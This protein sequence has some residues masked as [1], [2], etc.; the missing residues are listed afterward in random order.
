M[1]ITQFKYWTNRVL[2]LFWFSFRTTNITPETTMKSTSNS[3]ERRQGNRI[4]CKRTCSSEEVEMET[5]SEEKW[6]S[7]SGLTRHRISTIT[8]FGG[9]HQISCPY[10][11][12]RIHAF[13]FPPNHSIYRFLPFPQIFSRQ[14]TDSKVYKKERRHF[15]NKTNVG[16]RFNM[17]CFLVGDREWEIQG[18]LSLPAVRSQVPGLQNKR[19]HGGGGVLQARHRGIEPRAI[20]SDGEG[21]EELLG[22]WLLQWSKERPHADSWML[23]PHKE[24]QEIL[25]FKN[26]IIKKK[27]RKKWYYYCGKLKK[28]KN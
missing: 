1:I 3:W 26:I 8:P 13:V 14:R 12:N 18:G 6:D 5:L 24:T 20:Q 9:L 10:N 19:L 15:P 25:N 2:T 16:L 23:K 21:A 4:H 17:G 22:V 11:Y 28:K 27:L 7:I